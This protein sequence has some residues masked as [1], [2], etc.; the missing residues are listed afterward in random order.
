MEETEASSEDTNTRNKESQ[1][2][3]SPMT[4]RILSSDNNESQSVSKPQFL[5]IT[6]VY[7]ID[8]KS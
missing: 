7:N 3:K 5:L 8:S 2:E 1:I 4:Q 6:R